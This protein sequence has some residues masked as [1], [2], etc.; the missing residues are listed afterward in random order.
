MRIIKCDRCGKL[1]NLDQYDNT[2]YIKWT[3][4]NVFN[5][6]D[7]VPENP[8]ERCDYCEDCMNSILVFITTS[9]EH[10]KTPAA[11]PKKP[12]TPKRLDLG[13]MVALR[14][15]GWGLE[16]IAMELHCSAATVSRKLTELAKQEEEEADAHEG[17]D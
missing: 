7:V 10:K 8:L 6:A 3:W 11:E 1:I 9:P 12:D 4:R 17:K 5:P 15:A 14:K 2:G 13:K 16:K